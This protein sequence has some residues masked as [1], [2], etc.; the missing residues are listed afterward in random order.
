M[1]KKDKDFGELEFK[2]MWQKREPEIID[3]LGKKYPVLIQIKSYSHE[4]EITDSQREMYNNFKANGPKLISKSIAELKS[5]CEMAFERSGLT[6]ADIAEGLKPRSVL[7]QRNNT[8]GILFDCLWDEEHG[9]AVYFCEENSV[10]AS[11]QD[12]FI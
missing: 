10:K 1:H 8:W 9:V 3:F 7:F 4:D 12:S 2:Y 5:Y 11:S 6:D